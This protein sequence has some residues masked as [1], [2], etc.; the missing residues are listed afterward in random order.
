MRVTMTLP[1]RI[2]AALEAAS[3]ELGLEAAEY[4]KSMLFAAAHAPQG[5]TLK[6]DLPPAV[7][8]DLP[9]LE[10]AWVRLED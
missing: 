9:L 3:K 10:A 5:V 1:P 6:L 7:K 8:S 2:G 4:L